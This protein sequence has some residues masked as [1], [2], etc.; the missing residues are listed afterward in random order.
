M[1]HAKSN[2]SCVEDVLM[3]M[4]TLEFR[5]PEDLPKAMG[6][7][8]EAFERQIKFLVAARMYELG[9]ISSGRAAELAGIQRVEF[10]N[11][12]GRHQISVFNFPLSDL[13]QEIQEAR[14][15]AEGSD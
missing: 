5:Y 15:R 10:L 12:L 14:T 7:S 6:E 3:S 11:E 13:E 9:R 4:R 2:F 1:S 8:P